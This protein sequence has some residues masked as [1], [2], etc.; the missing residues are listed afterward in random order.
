MLPIFTS[1]EMSVLLKTNQSWT[2]GKAAKTGFIGTVA[3]GE[4][5]PQYRTRCDSESSKGK[6]E[7]IV[8]E[9]VSV[10]GGGVSKRKREE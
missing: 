7:F 10:R 2:S 4:E 9:Q 8:W 5:R 3:I 1:M 6:W